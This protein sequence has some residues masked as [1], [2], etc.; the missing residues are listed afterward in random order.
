M[1][2]LNTNDTFEEDH[3]AD[4]YYYIKKP[5]PF[6]EIG[7]ASQQDQLAELTAYC[8]AN[9]NPLNLVA[10]SWES[11]TLNI[12]QIPFTYYGWLLPFF[13]QKEQYREGAL[14]GVTLYRLATDFFNNIAS[15]KV[16][17]LHPEGFTTFSGEIQLIPPGQ[18]NMRG[19]VNPGGPRSYR[20]YRGGSCKLMIPLQVNPGVV[21]EIGGQFVNPT[22]YQV[23][24]IN[25]QQ[26]YQFNNNGSEDFIY[27]TVNLTPT[28]K[29]EILE[30]RL[31]ANPTTQALHVTYA[32][33]FPVH[34]T[35][36]N[37]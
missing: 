23:T 12:K 3:S 17:A 30:Q 10:P 5:Q 24:E 8:I 20:W 31:L 25:D 18:R 34:T 15:M 16:D 13:F 2:I 36:F 21:I 27:L 29:A 32:S 37:S 9:K 7:M 1:T 6:I 4:P 26:V 14:E 35:L 19:I 33:G 28:S 22:Q 11:S